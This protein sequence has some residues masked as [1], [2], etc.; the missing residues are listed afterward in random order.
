MWGIK[1]F[2]KFYAFILQRENVGNIVKKAYKFKKFLIEANNEKIFLV[3]N[4]YANFVFQILLFT[5]K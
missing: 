2:Q 1:A 3:Q 4:N 5:L